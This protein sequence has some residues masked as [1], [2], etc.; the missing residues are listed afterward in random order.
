LRYIKYTILVLLLSTGLTQAQQLPV[1]NQYRLNEFLVNPSFAGYD[2]FTSINIT[3]RE[4]WIGVPS[5]PKT[6]T[7]SFQTRLLKQSFQIKSKS[8]RKNVLKKS[9][10]GRVGVGGYLYSDRNG[11][12]SQVGAQLAYAYHIY[13]GSNQLSMG[14]AANYFQFSVDPQQLSFYNEETPDPA[15]D[16]IQRPFLVP[17]FSFGL[18]LTSYNFMFG[19]SIVQL[20]ASELSFKLYNYDVPIYKRHYY[21]V[22]KFREYIRPKWEYEPFVIVKIPEGSKLQM[23]L[24]SIFVYDK[25]YW[26]GLGYRRDYQFNDFNASVNTF[27]LLLGLRYD[28]VYFGYSFDYSLISL[29]SN[30]LGSHEFSLAIKFGDNVRR[31]RWLERY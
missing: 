8:I 7:L 9:R 29:L 31:Y 13:L 30:T 5:S 15:L 23:D 10:S 22:G 19:F 12:I 20:L 1:Y 14:V 2:G 26:F 27:I 3:G 17:D 24:S 4:Q 16:N 21:V 11:A 18:S 25:D 28:R 6:G